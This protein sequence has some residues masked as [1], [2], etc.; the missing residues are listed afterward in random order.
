MALGKHILPRLG[1]LPVDQVTRAA[2]E[3]WTVWAQSQMQAAPQAKAVPQPDPVDVRAP[4]AYSHDTL[5]QWWRVL[6]TVIKDMAADCNLPDP[7]AR[8][9]PP[10]RPQQAP[11]R[12]QRT[13]DT[14]GLADLVEAARQHTPER[15]AEIALL[16]LSGMRAGELYAL[17]WD[18]VDLDKGEVVIKRGVSRGK[19]TETTKTKSQRTVPL[20]PLLVD[21]LKGHRQKM[22]Q[23]QVPGF[24]SGLVFPSAVGTP[25]TANSLDKPFKRIATAM[26]AEIQLG[27]QVL[28][29]SMNS[30][31]IRQAVDRLTLR[32]IMGHTSEQ[33]SARYYGATADEKMAAVLP[34]PLRQGTTRVLQD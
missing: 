12:E 5:R 3:S 13:L 10:E 25:R 26:G 11:R 15:Y 29:R 9:R 34:L 4:Q 32:S 14:D 23:G 31:L 28:R 1:W 20:H 30:N 6:C 27:A 21:V 7:T 2:I 33:M 17:K 18:V 16:A 24:D 19:V 22:L 8:V